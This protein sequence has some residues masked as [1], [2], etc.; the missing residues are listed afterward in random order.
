MLTV[1]AG[2]VRVPT[3][4]VETGPPVLVTHQQHRIWLRIQKI[5]YAPATSHQLSVWVLH[6]R[7]NGFI[8][9]DQCFG[10]TLYQ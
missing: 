10:S 5:T 6:G 7:Y 8:V 2:H 3:P 1:A 9:H 4:P